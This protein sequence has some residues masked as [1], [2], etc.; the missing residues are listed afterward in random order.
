MVL[1]RIKV[2]IYFSINIYLYKDTKVRFQPKKGVIWKREYVYIVI[3]ILVYNIVLQHF[4]SIKREY[5]KK[6][7]VHILIIGDRQGIL[8]EYSRRHYNKVWYK[9]RILFADGK[10]SIYLYNN[11]T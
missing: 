10:K 4:I 1:E 8:K 3:Y 5:I 6:E 2:G 9:H 11:N 7:Q